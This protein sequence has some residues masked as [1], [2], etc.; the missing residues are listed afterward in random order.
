MAAAA[1][2]R[3]RYILRVP[4]LPLSTRPPAP[5]PAS[6]PFG[7]VAPVFPFPALARLAGRAQLGESRETVL[8][9]LLGARLAVANI[10]PYRLPA[11]VRE[12]RAR[13]ALAW[14]DA[15]N[16]PSTTRPALVA[17]FE[18]AGEG[19]QENIAAA[20]D[21][22]RTHA[23]DALDDASHAELQRLLRALMKSHSSTTEQPS[24][25]GASAQT[26]APRPPA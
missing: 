16:L 14:L 19:R 8:A 21:N 10:P 22:L 26:Q 18:A 24:G 25:T 12:A 6:P 3:S 11:E 15:I 1:P 20:L 7:L 23:A 17:L 13:A 9:T 5:A 4:S 2:S